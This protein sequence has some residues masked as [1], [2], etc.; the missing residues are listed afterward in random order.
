MSEKL[1]VIGPDPKLV[2]LAFKVLKINET[3]LRVNQGI[4]RL[5]EP[6]TVFQTTKVK[7]NET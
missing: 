2:D 6:I 5:L 1:E 4:I 3:V 7:K